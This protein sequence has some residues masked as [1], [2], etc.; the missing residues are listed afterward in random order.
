MSLNLSTSAV[1]LLFICISLVSCEPDDDPAKDL[2][3]SSIDVVTGMDLF[4]A[5]GQAIGRWREPNDKRGNITA[6]PVPGN[7]NV[8]IIGIQNIKRILVI[9]STC[10]RDT[11]TEDIIGLSQSTA[12]DIEDIEEFK[13]L[14][15][16]L[17]M[18][19]E[20]INLN[21]SDLNAGFYK[22]FYIE[23]EESI[24]RQNIYIDPN[25]NNFPDFTA[26]DTACP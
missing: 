19:S 14:D 12:Y 7:G 23:N 24:F 26:L 4:D 2:K 20:I 16:S 1:F 6:F 13:L 10:F 11:V 17:E 21:L 25:V 15:Q 22:I 9:P 18:S 5:N 3:Y 8:A